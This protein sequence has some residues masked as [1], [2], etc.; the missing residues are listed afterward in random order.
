MTGKVVERTWSPFNPLC[1]ECGRIDQAR[2]TGFSAE[3]ETVSYACTCGA[4]ATVPIV[5]GGKL[6]WRIDWPARWAMLGVS[7]EP[8][9]KDHSTQ[10]GSYDTGVRIAREVFGNEPPLPIPYE[11]I[12]LKGQGDMA[13]SKGNVLSIGSILEVAPP[14]ALRYLVIRERPQRSIG[15]DPGLPLLQLVDEYDDRAAAGRDERAVE[16]SSAGEFEPVGVPY[17]HL[18]VVAQAASFDTERAVA[19]L[20]RTGYPEVS[21][22]AV[23]RRLEYARRW[24]DSF[25]PD[26]LRFTVQKSLPAMAEELGPDQRRFLGRLADRLEQGMDGDAVHRLIYDLAGEFDDVKPALLFQAIYIV[27][28]GKPRGPRAGWFV[29]LLGPEACAARF[30]EA[31]GGER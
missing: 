9:G 1:G 5:G 28:L 30:R 13:A 2:V 19:I 24:L 8:F 25:A 12:R 10:G 27:L 17:K 4:E 18:V 29:A 20:R 6:V 7:I 15:F 31:S 3:Q 23:R 14:E 11:W 21:R 22:S 26:D 16:L